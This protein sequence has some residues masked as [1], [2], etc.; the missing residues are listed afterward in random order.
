MALISIV[1]PVYNEAH[2]I[3]N[4]IRSIRQYQDAQKASHCNFEL[5]VADDGSTDETC[6]VVERESNGLLCRILRSSPNRGKG[7]AVRRGML[8]A[9]GD[10]IL[11]CDADLSTPI[12]ELDKM[13]QELEN[14]ADVVFGSR[15]LPQSDVQVHQN[16]FRETMGK[17]FNLFARCLAFRGV[18]D[19]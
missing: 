12:G 7:H 14:G 5:I 4:T 11:F 17:I 13:I 10:I 15:A 9:H 8:A 16:I 18:H 1:I 6:R 2:R 3:G 19:S